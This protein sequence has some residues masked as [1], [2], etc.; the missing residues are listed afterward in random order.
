MLISAR[1]VKVHFPVIEYVYSVGAERS[2][3]SSHAFVCKSLNLGIM[4]SGMYHAA[5]STENTYRKRS[6]NTY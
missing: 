6:E 5:V 3:H 4:E 1:F 2:M